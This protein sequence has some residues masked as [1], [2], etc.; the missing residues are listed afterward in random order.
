[1]NFVARLFTSLFEMLEII[2]CPQTMCE[3]CGGVNECG[4]VK[5][6]VCGGVSQCGCVRCVGL[7]RYISTVY[8]CGY[9]LWEGV[10]VCVSM[11]M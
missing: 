3:V 10:W 9:I 2:G 11:L 1:M 5:V 4:C 6:C 8:M 7:W